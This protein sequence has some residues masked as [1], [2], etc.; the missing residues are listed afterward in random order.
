MS[1]SGIYGTRVWVRDPGEWDKLMQHEDSEDGRFDM[2][3]RDGWVRFTSPATARQ[4]KEEVL[5]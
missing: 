3:Q 5:G 2:G 1:A 4:A